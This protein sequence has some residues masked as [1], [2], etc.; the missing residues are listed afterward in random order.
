[1]IGALIVTH[2]G[3]AEEFLRAARTIE[4]G[5]EGVVALGLDWNADP[6]EAQGLVRNAISKVD[7][8]NGVL[9]LTDMFGGTPS[10]LAMPHLAEGKVEIVSGVNL[11]MVVKL[12]SKDQNA[13][14]L[15]E[16]A[17]RLREKGR[18]SI[19]VASEL[20]AAPDSGRI[21]RRKS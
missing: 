1:M 14:S 6:E 5:L 12:A 13:L 11:P 3:L 9:I 21:P 15:H 17:R 18:R 8:G 10:N 19:E 20:L 4:P 16:L 7:Q 2:G